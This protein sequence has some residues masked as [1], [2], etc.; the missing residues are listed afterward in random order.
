MGFVQRYPVHKCDLHSRRLPGEPTDGQAD[1]PTVLQVLSSLSFQCRS[2]TEMDNEA[3][4]PGPSLPARVPIGPTL[5][6]GQMG[7]TST[8]IESLGL[9]DR[10][11][12]I[13]R[14]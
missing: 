5:P 14:F 10:L 9:E 7:R 6:N 3:E 1:H 13:F 4:P 8:S 12:D 2:A 11:K